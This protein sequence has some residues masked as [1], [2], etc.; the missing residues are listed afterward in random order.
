MPNQQNK[1]SFFEGAVVIGMVV[2][3]DIVQG[4]G[5]WVVAFVI[6]IGTPFFFESGLAK[7]AAMAISLATGGTVNFAIGLIAGAIFSFALS[8]IIGPLIFWF[9]VRKKTPMVLLMAILGPAFI[10]ELFPYYNTLPYF[11]GATI[12]L[13]LGANGLF[14]KL[15]QFMLA[16]VAGA[17]VATVATT[18]QNKITGSAG[19]GVY[20]RAGAQAQLDEVSATNEEDVR[21]KQARS[22]PL[23]IDGIR[24]AND[25]I[26]TGANANTPFRLPQS[27]VA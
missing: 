27:K 5:Q 7:M 24:R 12:S 25:T 15:S 23:Q 20:A 1:I 3:F 14:K 11:T 9:F 16:G 13:I 26:P 19:R 2:F 10:S 17:S 22:Q 8:C 4:V 6:G 21:E 18:A